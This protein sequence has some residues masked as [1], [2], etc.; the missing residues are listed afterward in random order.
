MKLP[1]HEKA[2]VAMEKLMNYIL[3]TSH[4]VGA[5]KAAFF[6]KV[7]FTAVNATELRDELL[8]IARGDVYE[9]EEK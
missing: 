8:A 5:S 1:N 9:V 7:G 2:I 4:P 6:K 3:S